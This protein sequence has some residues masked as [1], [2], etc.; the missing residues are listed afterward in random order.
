MIVI[1]ILCLVLSA[2]PSTVTTQFQHWIRT[3]SEGS[4]DPSWKLQLR[5]DGRF[6]LF[7]DLIGAKTTATAHLI[8][9][10][11]GTVS[12][13]IWSSGAYPTSYF[14]SE[15][16][17]LA[18]SSETLFV[19]GNT[20]QVLNGKG[21]LVSISADFKTS[22]IT[23]LTDFEPPY[24]T[25]LW[26]GIPGKVLL[27]D[28]GVFIRS[29]LH[30][31]SDKTRTA[32]VVHN[33]DTTKWAFAGL[34]ASL[35]FFQQGHIYNFNGTVRTYTYPL[36]D[37]N[38]KQWEMK[39]DKGL[40]CL[41]YKYPGGVLAGPPYNAIVDSSGNYYSLCDQ[42]K[43]N[44]SYSVWSWTA[45][46]KFRWASDKI[47][48]FEINQPYLGFAL[49]EDYLVF[50]LWKI[51]GTRTLYITIVACEAATGRIT[52]QTDDTELAKACTGALVPTKGK[53]IGHCKW[54]F[55]SLSDGTVVYRCRS[56]AGHELYCGVDV[57]TGTLLKGSVTPPLAR[58]SSI[59]S[60]SGMDAAGNVVACG[61]YSH[62]A[63]TTVICSGAPTA[64]CLREPKAGC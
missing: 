20:S 15:P 48:L 55:Q 49:H 45:E 14:G 22:D 37:N 25:S 24:G 50:G 7:V 42:G 26:M 43:R 19:W 3:I 41:K 54:T 17:Y 2:I 57:K 12:K 61:T 33:I 52:I 58:N 18:G 21:Y 47:P 46:G 6:V 36:S 60:T 8:S 32:T 63:Q 10:L 13:S 53:D 56:K 35:A 51:N 4:V 39:D 11:D 29:P 31:W 62:R 64:G 40:A 23:K 27:R 1:L 38:Y 9:S 5:N 16:Y 34:G 30:I 59:F 28:V 44:T